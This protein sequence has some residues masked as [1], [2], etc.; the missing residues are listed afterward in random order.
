MILCF[1]P[2]MLRPLLGGTKGV[3]ISN[4]GPPSEMHTARNLIWHRVLLNR[5]GFAA[6]VG[7]AFKTP[8]EAFGNK[9]SGG[10]GPNAEL[11]S[12]FDQ[13]ASKF[14]GSH[15]RPRHLTPGVSS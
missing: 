7:I 10:L 9:G 13:L 3:I 2:D 8:Q 6:N 15:H 11:V 1:T 5:R 14:K 4:Q 12:I